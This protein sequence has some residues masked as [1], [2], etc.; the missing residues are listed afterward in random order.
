[1]ENTM[2]YKGYFTNICYSA[3]DKVLHGKIEGIADLVTFECESLDGIENEFHNAVDDYIAFCEENGKSP[4]KTYKGT[5]NV[6]IE[7]N[8]HR[9]ISL[10]AIKNGMSLNQATEAAIAQY[11][12]SQNPYA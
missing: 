9:E 10:L 11:V 1:M 4:E 7:P 8:L 6:R 2:Y 12:S 3:E 5:F